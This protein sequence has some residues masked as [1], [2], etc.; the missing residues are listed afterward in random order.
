[1][2]CDICGYAIKPDRQ[3][4]EVDPDVW[5]HKTC[6]DVGEFDAPPERRLVLVGE[7]A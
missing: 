2:I 1:M 6:L 5:S 7:D 4:V 3:K